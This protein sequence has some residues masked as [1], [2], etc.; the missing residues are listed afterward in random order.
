MATNMSVV[1]YV[2]MSVC[3]L[4]SVS[5]RSTF[6]AISCPGDILTTECA[7]MGGGATVWRG[8]ALQCHSNNRDFISLR[9]SQFLES[10]KPEGTCNN[11]AI[12]ARALGVVNGSYISQ[13]NVR[14]SIELNN[15]TVECVYSH[16]FTNTV[17][18]QIQIIVL[19]TG[20]QEEMHNCE[21]II[22]DLVQWKRNISR[23]R[24]A[25]VIYLACRYTVGNISPCTHVEA[26]TWVMVINVWVGV[27]MLL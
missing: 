12:A 26:S 7:I 20:K 22:I 2:L 4:V 16:N 23:E 24:S 9:H 15:T 8:T 11:G 25:C 21:S 18:K 19:A 6:Q 5:A 1:F 13:L 27:V 14:V 3:H 17:I 10:D